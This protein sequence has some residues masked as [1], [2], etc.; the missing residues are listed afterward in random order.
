[1]QYDVVIVG[2]S[3][4]GLLCAREIARN[5][6]KVLVIEEDHEIGTPE[7]CGGLVSI[8]G[9]EH[10]GLIPHRKSYGHFIEKAQIFAP[11]GNSFTIDA[12]K[13]QVVEISRRDLDKQV[14]IQAQKNGAQ[15]IVQ[16]S[17]REI[18]SQ[19]VS[20]SDGIIKSRIVVDA[21][22]VS[23]LI[24]SNRTG[25]LS[26]GQYQIVADWI[27]NGKIEIYFDQK[28]YPGFF[29]WI[30]PV[31]D[32]IGKVGVAGKGINPAEALETFL[33]NKGIHSIIRKIFAP[34]WINGPIKNF[35]E[36]NLVIIGD[37]AGQSKPTTAGGIYSCG[38][39]GL[40][41]G[42]AISKYL[43]TENKA[44]LLE[45]QER[46]TAKFG[47]EFEKQILARKILQRLDNESINKM[48]DSIS[49]QIIK[50]I[51]AKED[52]DFHTSSIIKLLGL[53]RSLK[54]AQVI[55]GGEIKKLI[56]P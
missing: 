17:C 34:I 54:A 33:K 6:F 41:A 48:F 25:I 11:N 14:A 50:E 30:I 13:Q 38:I 16:T 40:L 31:A 47:K 21:R 9:L 1:V 32:G 28:K 49:P 2:G 22:G 46:W 27:K 51:S 35:V 20:T 18:T 24:R 45:Y 12:T 44:D 5:G 43:E 37:A 10:L 56:Q 29:A 15:V 53:K 39:G 19:G 4:S 3:I 23:S 36:N 8:S 26:S 52:F 55:F 7:H 42:K